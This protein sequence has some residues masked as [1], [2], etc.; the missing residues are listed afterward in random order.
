MLVPVWGW[1]SI[2]AGGVLLVAAAVV[3]S[4]LGWR[5]AE[6]RYLLR[7]VSRREAIDAVRQALD[8]VV[9]QSRAGER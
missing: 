6:R 5:A 4:I 3:G 8:D 7:L 9:L 2:G 1:V